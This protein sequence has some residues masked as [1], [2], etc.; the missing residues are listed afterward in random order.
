MTSWTNTRATSRAE[1]RKRVALPLLRACL[2][3]SPQLP[4]PQTHC[5]LPPIIAQLH[6]MQ[7]NNLAF[8]LS[9]P[10]SVQILPPHAL[11]FVLPDFMA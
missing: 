11:H 10:R 2:A 5:P 4:I 7:R 8:K 9:P 1:R 6:Y 3:P